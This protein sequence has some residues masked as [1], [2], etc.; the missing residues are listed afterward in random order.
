MNDR[1]PV[2][3]FRTPYNP[4]Q[5]LAME[6]R[7]LQGIAADIRAAMSDVSRYNVEAARYA[8][9]AA[10]WAAAKFSYLFDIG[11]GRLLAA[12]GISDG[13]IGGERDSSRIRQYPLSAGRFYHRGLAIPHRLG[14]SLDINLVPQLGQINIGPFREFERRA[15]ATPGA[16][17]FAFWKYS[18][19][20][21]TPIGVDQG[22]LI[23]GEIPEIRS[24]GNYVGPGGRIA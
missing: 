22:Q 16:L 9:I 12:C 8:E 14:G 23:P 19:P 4:I 20:S 17:Y 13:R 21:Q 7:R 10:M 2:V 24:F 6:R 18:G 5:A 1:P 11:S 3:D 15:V